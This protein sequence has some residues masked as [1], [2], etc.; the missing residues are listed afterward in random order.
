MKFTDHLL[1]EIRS[2]FPALARMH[3]SHQ[4]VFFDG[5]A[6]TQVPQRVI[7]AIGD[8]LI[9]RNANHDGVFATSIESDQQ[10]HDVH[11]AAANLVGTEDP[12]TI[13]F[14][15]NMTTLTLALSRAL[16]KTWNPGDEII[17][18]RLEHD[19]NFTP[20][21][22]AAE[23]AGVHVHY[24][25]IDPADCTLRVDQYRDLLSDRTRLVA[26]CCASNAVGTL[27]PVG[28]ICKMAAD[29]GALTFLDAVHFAPHARIDVGDWNCDFLVCSAYK[30][31]GPHVGIMYGRREL[32]QSLRP[33]KLRPSP[34][35]L[36]GRWMTGTQ[37]HECLAGTLAAIDYLADVGR[38]A[39]ADDSLSRPDALAAAYQAIGQY[40]QRLLRQLLDGL[41]TLVELKV[42]GITASDQLSNRLPTVSITH[43]D[44]PAKALAEKLAD[45]G[46][47]VWHGN[48]YALPLTER[49]GVEPDGM[50]RIGLVHYNTAAEVE[51]LIDCLS[52]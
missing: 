31:F 48:Y 38:A 29:A 30:F 36:P 28:D 45:A 43:Q 47:Y 2:Q 33:Y 22:L 6:G 40:E 14:G 35:D 41:G 42:W 7:D 12:G 51:R 27:T 46:I 8:Y 15:A 25:D 52:E 20:W 44:L 26:V 11:R 10:L 32:L 50:V 17:L 3:G 19:A 21:V 24:V 5:P 4:A 13:V 16:A 9:H 34:D 23:D 1:A 18:S 49:L 37:N 39:A